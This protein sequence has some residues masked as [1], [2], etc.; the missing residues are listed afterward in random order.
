M[1]PSPA[2][3]STSS[4]LRTAI[5]QYGRLA[6]AV[7]IGV[8]T[9]SFAGLYLA[10][11]SSFDVEGLLNR[12]GLLPSPTH[13]PSS[14]SPA[15]AAPPPTS[16]SADSSE[17]NTALSGNDLSSAGLPDSSS[18]VAGRKTDPGSSTATREHA[19][20]ESSGEMSG[21]VREG[22]AGAGTTRANVA[23]GSAGGSESGGAAAA[24]LIGSGGALAVAWLCNKAL[25]PVRVP[26]TLALTPPI[27]RFLTARG[28]RI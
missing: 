5:A 20:A 23:V 24:G 17:R 4:R 2:A 27:A 10:I 16:H 9:V 18:S 21:A 12:V 3:T 14:A 25:I 26:I 6:V 15:D 13:P 11:R 19:R 7:H 28:Y 1:P 22:P 8:S